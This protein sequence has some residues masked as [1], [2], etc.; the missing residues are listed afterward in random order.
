M[1]LWMLLNDGEKILKY[2]T[3]ESFI[4]NT[5]HTSYEMIV[6]DNVE[7]EKLDIG[8]CLEE[9]LYRLLENDIPE[10][11]IEYVTGMVNMPD[12]NLEEESPYY[13]YIT[14]DKGFIL[15]GEILRI[16]EEEI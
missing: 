12:V 5:G 7:I 14:I 6:P 16:Y 4:C 1:D 8:R 13:S 3:T 11:S 9:T 15:P 2:V 10:A